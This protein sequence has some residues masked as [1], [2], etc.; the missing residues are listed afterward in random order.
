MKRKFSVNRN[1]Y[2]EFEVLT[3]VTM[4]SYIFWCVTPCSPIKVNSVSPR[5]H[6]ILSQIIEFFKRNLF[7]LP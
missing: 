2:V 3:A 6:G 7:Y 5:L 1:I 4:K